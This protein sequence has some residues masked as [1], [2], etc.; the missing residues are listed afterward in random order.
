MKRSRYPYGDLALTSLLRNFEWS[1]ALTVIACTLYFGWTCYSLPNKAPAPENWQE[2]F[3]FLASGGILILVS[4][5]L[6]QSISLRLIRSHFEEKAHF[7]ATLYHL[8]A[9]VDEQKPEVRVDFFEEYLRFMHKNPAPQK[10]HLLNF[11]K[12]A[13]YAARQACEE[14]IRKERLKLVERI[15]DSASAEVIKQRGYDL[16]RLEAML[17]YLINSDDPAKRLLFKTQQQQVGGI[18]I[19]T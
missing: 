2:Y 8:A 4:F 15:H 6:F 11:P 9:W 12:P 3:H 13:S 5:T 1:R 14:I 10:D 16:E 19:E 17:D 7:E 18:P